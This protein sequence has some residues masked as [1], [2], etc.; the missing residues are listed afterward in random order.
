MACRIGAGCRSQRCN[1]D[2]AHRETIGGGVGGAL[3]RR[4]ITMDIKQLQ[5]L[6]PYL[7][8]F[9][10]KP[11]DQGGDVLLYGNAPLLVSMD[12]RVLEQIANVAFLR[13]I[14]SP[15]DY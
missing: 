9:P 11:A 10:G 3:R 13:W 6:K 14:S 12:D 7:W 8:R 1:F 2:D 5:Q 15:Y 4:C